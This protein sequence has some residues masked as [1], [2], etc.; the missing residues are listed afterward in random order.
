MNHILSF[1]SI[2]IFSIFLGSQ[3]TE[4]CILAPYWKTLSHIEFYNYYAKFGPIIGRFYTILTIIATLI[5]LFVSI[6][7]YYKKTLALR[8][9][10]IST[11]FAF[12]VIAIFY[13]HFKEI[14]QQFYQAA[15]TPN[16][17]Q[18]VLSDWEHY[19]WLR[20]FFELLSLTFLI[21]SLNMLN[22]KKREV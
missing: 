13:M 20:V 11:L 3:I 21:L 16:K 5:P 19:H 15:F 4:G 12:L 17:L 6:Y 8:Y 10:L 7:C 14:N 2:G 22:L 9:S 18:A 1:I